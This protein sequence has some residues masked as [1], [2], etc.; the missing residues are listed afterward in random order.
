MPL[1]SDRARSGVGLDVWL[2]V[3][4]VG[5]IVLVEEAPLPLDEFCHEIVIG[6]GDFI[7]D[8][9]I[10][11]FEVDNG[12]SGAILQPVRVSGS[13]LETRTRSR[14]EFVRALVG[15]QCRAAGDDVDELVL[16]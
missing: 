16:P 7:T 12:R 15:T 6:I 9:A 5:L 3:I 2:D 1:E 4:S 14:P 10:A 8:A 13:R 11:D